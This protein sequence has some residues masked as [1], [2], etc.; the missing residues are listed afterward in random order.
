[1][2][3]DINHGAGG[4]A[5]SG[6]ANLVV[7]QISMATDVNR[8]LANNLMERI[9]ERT[10]LNRAYKRVK[11]NKGAK[12]V[13]GMTVDELLPYLKEHGAEIIQSLLSGNY[14]PQTVRGVEIP[15]PN[16][17]KR[18]LGIP[19]VLDR[20][21]QQAILQIME[22][23]F[24][25]TFSESSFGFRPKRSAHQAL[26]SASEHVK[27]GLIVVVDVDL[28]KYFDRVN[29]DILMSRIARRIG[30]RR[31]LKIL[32]EFLKAGILIDGVCM[33]RKEGTPQD[34]PLSPLLSNILLD[35]LDKELERRG[36]KF[37]R[38]ADD[39]NIYVRTLQAGKRVMESIKQFLG[40]R[41]KL[42]I[43]E[44]KSAVALVE[45]R[46]FLGYRIYCSGN[47][48]IAPESLKRM[49]T[50]VRKL[51]KRNRGVKF[52][53]VIVE[54]NEYLRGWLNYFQL[55]NSRTVLLNLDQ[56]LRRRLRSY[57]LKQCKRKHATAKYLMQ[58]G[59]SKR[60]AWEIAGLGKSW[61]SKSRNPAVHGAMTTKWFEEL[62]LFSLKERFVSL[63]AQLK[64]PYA[65]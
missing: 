55:S 22:P 63:K 35:E 64:P 34:G 56:W 65:K 6:T 61:W 45:E 4:E 21:V 7:Q 51:T 62:K 1:M 33:R 9:C 14:R 54:L 47:L 8:N 25:P 42:R 48:S 29:H 53:R 36:H 19:T 11:S 27:S 41:L 40:K 5:G 39:C 26:K 16:G 12:G 44:T 20:F 23:I 28:E 2:I 58:L 57:R 46:K 10:N 17:G 49:R 24:D 15:K 50:K 60:N 52:E 13:D 3:N 37:C 31:L 38:Y 43:N 18:L 59:V 32:R 30:D